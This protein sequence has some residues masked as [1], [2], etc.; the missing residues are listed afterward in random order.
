M[1]TPGPD[2]HSKSIKNLPT[3]KKILENSFTVFYM[4]LII[5]YDGMN[6]DERDLNIFK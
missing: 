2:I 5:F 3:R 4:S 1:P 6:G